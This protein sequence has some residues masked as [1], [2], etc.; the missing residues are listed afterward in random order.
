MKQTKQSPVGTSYHMHTI[1]ATVNQLK[2]VLGE[3]EYNPN[4]GRDKV[5]F[6]WEMETDNGDVF[7]VYDYKEYRTISE[8]EI[9][10]WHIGGKSSSVTA[11]AQSEIKNA[12]SE[13]NNNTTQEKTIREKALSKDEAIAAMLQGK[14]VTHQHFT[15]NEWMKLNGHFEVEFEDGCKIDVDT[16]W[17]DRKGEGWQTGWSIYT[18][19]P[20]PQEES[21]EEGELRMAYQSADMQDYENKTGSYTPSPVCIEEGGKIKLWV[22]GSGGRAGNL[23]GNELLLRTD[24]ATLHFN[25]E[26]EFG[27]LAHA[28]IDRYNSHDSLVSALK[29]ALFIL[30]CND[31][32]DERAEDIRKV[33]NRIK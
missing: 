30:D 3:P 13:T 29:Q 27:K 32:N 33:L 17:K 1:S 16:F 4:D 12:L 11:L 8:D 18:P 2:S 22:T 6:E 31:L 25:K 14:K 20:Q 5:N 23:T 28:M 7:T 15:D 26:S 10:E 19:H 9:I 24:D 21:K